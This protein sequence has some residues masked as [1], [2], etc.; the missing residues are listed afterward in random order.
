ML[1]KSSVL[2]DIMPCTHMKVSHSFRGTSP[3]SALKSEISMKQAAGRA[4][5]YWL[6]FARVHGI[7]TQKIER[8]IYVGL[9]FLNGS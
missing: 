5:Q 3:F 1:I 4:L 8:L 7:I 6:T 2:G 9:V